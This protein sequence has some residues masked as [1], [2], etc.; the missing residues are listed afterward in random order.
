M[1]RTP[2]RL[3]PEFRVRIDGSDLPVKAAMEVLEVSALQDVDAPGMFALRLANWDS[4]QMRITW[5]DDDL[6]GTGRE[7]EILMGYA[8]DLHPVLV[9]EITGIEPEFRAGEI[10]EV[11]VRGYDRR[12]R[13]MRGRKTRSYTKVKDSE[14]AGQIAGEAG[15]T[16]RAEDSRVVH[17]Y[18]LQHNQ[19][20]LE[21][22]QERARRIGYEVMVEGKDLHFRPRAYGSGEALTLARTVDLEE[23]HP[24]LTSLGIAPEVAVHGWN[25]KDK[26][27]LVGKAAAGD[28][29]SRMGGSSS[30]P[31]AVESA[32]GT[33]VA[34]LVDHPVL[35][36]AEADQIA[37][38]Q[39]REMALAYIGGEGVALGRADLKAGTV[40][41]IDGVGKRFS[42]LYYIP[43]VCHSYSPRRGYR[44]AFTFRRNAT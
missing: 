37:E 17:E 32:F 7:V 15:L 22:L 18:L 33:A 9:G 4:D 34:A 5:A 38:G 1:A 30:G 40:I 20:D 2:E 8:G 41:K 11:V 3:A 43:S 12:H 23:L 31:A 27:A 10:P 21:F 39:L 19:T 26:E 42:G 29:G 13:L 44:T 28:E 25:V 36:Q 6:F 16:D 24:R 14:V 35:S